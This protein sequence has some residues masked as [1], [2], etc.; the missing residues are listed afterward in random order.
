MNADWMIQTHDLS[1]CYGDQEVI[2]HI[3]LEV[4]RGERMALF[5]PSGAGKTTLIRI[6]AGL[7][8]PTSGTVQL[9]EQYPALIFQEPRLFTYMTVEENVRLPWKVRGMAWTGQ[10]QS[11]FEEWLE[12]AELSSWKGYYP[13]QLSGG[14]RQKVALIRGLLCHP[15]LAL[16]DEPFQ[17]INRDS[18][19]AIIEHIR[20]RNPELTLLLVTHDPEEVPMLADSV[21]YFTSNRLV[22]P[23]KLEAS[24]FLDLFSQYINPAGILTAGH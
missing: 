22:S 15:A 23:A 8:Q 17:S 6:L 16:L 12:V 4:R 1:K 18:R 3:S 2:H 11:E 14:M 24:R 20:S 5:A 13:Y 9:N 19:T 21:C 7:E 10:V